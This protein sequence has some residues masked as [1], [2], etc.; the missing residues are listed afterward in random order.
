MLKEKDEI[1]TIIKIIREFAQKYCN[2]WIDF[3]IKNSNY[4]LAYIYV[5][6]VD[7]YSRLT[8]NAII[9]KDSNIEVNCIYYFHDENGDSYSDLKT[10]ILSEVNWKHPNLGRIILPIKE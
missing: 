6:G 2:G 4:N 7:Q 3:E 10:E 5:K 9:P 1:N 8:L